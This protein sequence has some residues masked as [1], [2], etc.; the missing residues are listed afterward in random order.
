MT[1]ALNASFQPNNDQPLDRALKIGDGNIGFRL[2]VRRHYLWH[3]FKEKSGNTFPAFW[4]TITPF[5][6]NHCFAATLQA[7][8]EIV[9]FPDLKVLPSTPTDGTCNG[10]KDHSGC[11]DGAL[12]NQLW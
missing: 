4:I 8:G 5:F 10:N 9:I 6:T 12:S 3:N 1:G 7:T 2:V 11:E